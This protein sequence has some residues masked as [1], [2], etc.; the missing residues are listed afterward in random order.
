MLWV[1]VF[2]LPGFGITLDLGW[3]GKIALTVEIIA[4]IM[5]IVLINLVLVGDNASAIALG[6][7][8]TTACS[9]DHGGC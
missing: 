8:R 5:F 6:T 1:K 4:A 9:V 7:G 3:L 2:L